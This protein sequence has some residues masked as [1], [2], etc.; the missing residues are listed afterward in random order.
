MNKLF[1]SFIEEQILSFNGKKFKLNDLKNKY[2]N[3]P[4]LFFIEIKDQKVLHRKI[5]NDFFDRKVRIISMLKNTIKKYKIKDTIIIFHIYDSYYWE[6]NIPVFNFILPKG[7]SG[8]IFPTY[9]FI[10]NKFLKNFN[11]DEIK[12][13]FSLYNSN[14]IKNNIYFKGSDTTAKSNDIRNKLSHE[15]L[16]LKI[17]VNN[18]QSEPMYK[19]KDHKYLV[20]LP[21]SKPWSIRFKYL[22]L[23]EKVVIRISFFNSKYDETGYWRQYVDIFYN[24]HKDYIHLIYDLDYEKPISNNLY[25]KIKNDILNIYNKFEKNPKLYSKYV[26]NINKSSLKV[27]NDYT[28]KYI[29]KLIN[30]YTDSLFI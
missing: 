2:E 18:N 23:A 4:K 16:P 20:D 6:G 17:I 29:S 22:A 21:G 12:N 19:L 25:T 10:E 7:K 24:E 26:N 14:I 28:Y 30:S 8:F 11:Y 13:E 15:K 1:N 27:N 3:H 9:D 5:V